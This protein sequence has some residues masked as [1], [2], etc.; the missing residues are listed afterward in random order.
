MDRRVTEGQE[1][2]LRAVKSEYG[3]ADP[4]R[5]SQNLVAAQASRRREVG[6]RMSTL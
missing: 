2:I 6:Q 5:K 4:N 3:R 1:M